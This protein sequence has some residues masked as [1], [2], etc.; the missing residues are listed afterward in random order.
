[1]GWWIFGKKR[2]EGADE[3]YKMQSLKLLER[4]KE[5]KRNL[6]STKNL[7][8]RLQSNTNDSVNALS[9]NL[10]YLPHIEISS[11]LKNMLSFETKILEGIDLVDRNI[12]SGNIPQSINNIEEMKKNLYNLK[13]H[14][15]NLTKIIKFNSARGYV[16]EPHISSILKEFGNFDKIYTNIE[17]AKLLLLKAKKEAEERSKAFK[18]L[19]VPNIHPEVE[20]TLDELSGREK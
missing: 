20:R 2:V 6:D 4:F 14:A 18:E 1:M 19:N 17:E 8:F 3:A 16:V 12:T 5:V 10:N 13:H 11:A 9:H 7:V 15:T